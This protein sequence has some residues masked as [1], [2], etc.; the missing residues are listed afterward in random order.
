MCG[1]ADDE[2][3]CRAQELDPLE[4]IL[5]HLVGQTYDT[6]VALEESKKT[7]GLRNRRDKL[8]YKAPGPV[9]SRAAAKILCLHCA[10]ANEE[11]FVFCKQCGVRNRSMAG[12]P[13]LCPPR[14]LGTTEIVDINE[15][16]L[17]EKSLHQASYVGDKV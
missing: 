13:L 14:V 5:R 16:A 11:D 9:V 6:I 3:F 12:P 17:E 2:P 4:A 8:E 7:L 1:G 10:C 15:D